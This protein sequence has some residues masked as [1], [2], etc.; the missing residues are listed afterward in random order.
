MRKIRTSNRA[1]A[2]AMPQPAVATTLGDVDPATG[3]LVETCGSRPRPRGLAVRSGSSSAPERVCS[4][5]GARRVA[6]PSRLPSLRRFAGMRPRNRAGRDRDR[7]GTSAS[8][9]RRLRRSGSPRARRQRLRRPVRSSVRRDMSMPEIT[10]T[11]SKSLTRAPMRPVKL[12]RTVAIRVQKVKSS[13]DR[14]S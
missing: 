4:S 6:V 13:T 1:S 12:V 10:C 8:Q 3:N 2:V 11:L 5:C 7:Q 9:A 14:L